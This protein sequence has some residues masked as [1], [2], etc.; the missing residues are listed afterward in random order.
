MQL[1]FLTHI[2]GSRKFEL[3]DGPLGLGH[4]FV[5]GSSFLQRVQGPLQ[6]L[7]DQLGVST[8]LAVPN[9][10][11][12]L[13]VAF[14]SSSQVATL[15]L[16]VGSVLP[17]GTTA[18]GHAY[19]WALPA[20]EQH[21]LIRRIKR[22]VGPTTEAFVERGIL[23]G[24]AELDATGTCC[25]SNGYLR[26]TFGIALPVRIGRQAILMGLSCGSAVLRSD[27]ASEHRRITPVLKSAASKLQALM[28]DEDGIP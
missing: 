1:G 18:I 14:Q 15:R 8:A 20:A 2:A 9:G 17:M 10:L 3:A 21:D 4:A 27:L 6:C 28:S 16:G 22:S 26:D 5:E 11:D 24:I 23:G 7:A 12:M 13:C 25:V 19:M